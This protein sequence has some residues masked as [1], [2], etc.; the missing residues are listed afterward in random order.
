MP[1]FT[2]IGCFAHC[3]MHVT[4]LG[5][6]AEKSSRFYRTIRLM[7]ALIGCQI[8]GAT[9]AMIAPDAYADENSVQIVELGSITFY[10]PREWLQQG[11]IQLFIEG[12]QDRVYRPSRSKYM[13]TDLLIISNRPDAWKTYRPF[14]ESPL[15][16]LIFLTVSPGDFSKYERF[17]EELLARTQA[18][19]TGDATLVGKIWERSPRSYVVLGSESAFRMGQPLIIEGDPKYSSAPDALSRIA[20]ARYRV[21][22]DIELK[23]KFDLKEFP[24]ERWL[25]MDRQVERLVTYL[26]TPK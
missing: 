26:R 23:M 15:P 8:I 12:Q 18:V 10:V 16:R 4:D 6:S 3:W 19:I 20:W 5:K 11:Q 22:E 9:G 1:G 17:T 25:E 7:G 2:A 21:S 13:A 24:P 14:I